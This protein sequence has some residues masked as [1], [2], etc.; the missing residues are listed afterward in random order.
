MARPLAL[1]LL[2]LGGALAAP[3]ATPPC[4]LLA[5]CLAPDSCAVLRETAPPTF[6]VTLGTTVGPV[7]IEVVSAWAP[8]YA[9]RLW[10]LARLQYFVGATFYRML[11]RN[12]T[13]AFVVQFGYNGNATVDQCWDNHL[14][15][16]ATWSVHAPGNV[17]GTVAFSMG[18]VD[19]TGANPNCTSP[20]Y[21]AQ[22]FSTN[23]FINL[24]D[25]TRLDAPGFSIVGVVAAADGS[26]ARVDQFYAGYG[27]CADLCPAG[28]TDPFC[29][30]TG[31]Q[32]QGV[33]MDR[34]VAE[35]EDY[36]HPNFP[37]LDRVL[38]VE[39]QTP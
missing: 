31:A 8:P 24:A 10:Q 3:R 33:S 4:D 13:E 35:G 29:V 7:T 1:L 14:T 27:E 38:A 9:D 28:S 20:A 6:A 2:L 5:A 21:C 39:V 32:C 37:R 23:I 30:G 11:R 25:N 18:A 36:L 17:R 22:G 15:S 12:A 26:M 34:L 19:N 16:N